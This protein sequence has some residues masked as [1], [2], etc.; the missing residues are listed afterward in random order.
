MEHLRILQEQ[1]AEYQKG[2]QQGF[3]QNLLWEL[4][5]DPGE[6]KEDAEPKP[7][8]LGELEGRILKNNGNVQSFRWTVGGNWWW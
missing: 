7:A 3:N 5:K 4:S 2:P 8:Q 1:L 6:L